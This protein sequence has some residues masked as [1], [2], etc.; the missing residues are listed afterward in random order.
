MAEECR[1]IANDDRRCIFLLPT[2]TSASSRRPGRQKFVV[3][4]SHESATAWHGLW[5]VQT[6]IHRIHFCLSEP[7]AQWFFFD[8]P[9]I[10]SF[11]YL[12]T[13]LRLNVGLC[14]S[15]TSRS[16]NARLLACRESRGPGRQRASFHRNTITAGYTL[17]HVGRLALSTKAPT[18]RTTNF[19]RMPS[20]RNS[21]RFDRIHTQRRH[22]RA[23]SYIHHLTLIC[24]VPLPFLTMLLL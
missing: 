12:L 21:F 7:V 19:T 11:I 23:N 18:W 3:A 4:G 15:Q 2:P 6:S 17:T 5:T 8:A 22:G 10:N 9:R 16:A 14:F 1:L 24:N 13:Y 20:I